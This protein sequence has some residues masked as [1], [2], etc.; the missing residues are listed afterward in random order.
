M[1]QDRGAAGTRRPNRRIDQRGTGR[2]RP[3]RC[4]CRRRCGAG[5]Q[6]AASAEPDEPELQNVLQLDLPHVEA[7]PPPEPAPRFEPERCAGR[8]SASIR[9]AS[10]GRPMPTIASRSAR[11]NSRLDRP[12][13]RRRFRAAVARHRAGSCARSAGPRRRMRWRAARPGSES[14]STGQPTAAMYQSN[15]R[16]CRCSTATASFPGYRGSGIC[17]DLDRLTRLD[18][19]RRHQFTV[20]APTPQ[21]RSAD[22][23]QAC[24]AGD[25]PQPDLPAEPDVEASALPELPRPLL[26]ENSPQTDLDIPVQTPSDPSAE[27]REFWPSRQRMCCRSARSAKPNRRC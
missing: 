9:C 4:L 16:D 15:Y 26:P 20:E 7:S 11:M 6:S 27:L 1:R 24:P 21:P 8:T 5:C 17:R 23:V 2:V 22:I 10:S 12:A 25:L 18:T 13:N 19:L 3:V 14:S